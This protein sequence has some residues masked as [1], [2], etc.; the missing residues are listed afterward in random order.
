MVGSPDGINNYVYE[1]DPVG[2]TYTQKVSTIIAGF[3]SQVSFTLNDQM[4]L[5]QFGNQSSDSYDPVSDAWILRDSGNTLNNA[6][7][8]LYPP[9]AYGLVF[10]GSLFAFALNGK[11]YIGG[12][13]VMDLNTM[14]QSVSPYVFEFNPATDAYNVLTVPAVMNCNILFP[15]SFELNGK[16]YL[17]GTVSDPATF[18]GSA[19]TFEFN[20]SGNT[21]ITK[22]SCNC[23][24]MSHSSFVLNNQAYVN[25][26]S[27]CSDTTPVFIF[28]PMANTWTASDSI[29]LLDTGDVRLGYAVNGKG[30]LGYGYSFNSQC[31]INGGHTQLYEYTPA[32]TSTV[33]IHVPGISNIVP[34]PAAGSFVL[35]LGAPAGENCTVMLTDLTGKEADCRNL[36]KGQTDVP[37]D[38]SMLP[39]GM[40]FLRTSD[41][42][43]NEKIIVAR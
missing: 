37:F 36:T 18:G 6:M 24:P 10:N 34:N 12:L 2:N 31:G 41:G 28:D 21:F 39:A 20:P 14:L 5:V 26:N 27:I 4:Y 23:G 17:T 29:V 8:S 15:V 43:V 19:G 35:H 9:S 30:Y 38:V 11:A 33:G 42:T 32:I 40:Y 13:T 7:L 1:Y 16:G 22:A 3:N 25:V